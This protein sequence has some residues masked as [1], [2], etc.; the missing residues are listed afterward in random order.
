MVLTS[1]DL[2]SGY[3]TEQTHAIWNYLMKNY[4]KKTYNFLLDCWFFIHNSLIE[5]R[6][7]NIVLLLHE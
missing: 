3:K 7:L 4:N 1:R 2:R 5:I 6:F